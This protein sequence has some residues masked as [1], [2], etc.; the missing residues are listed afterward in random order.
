MYCTKLTHTDDQGKVAMVDT[1]EKPETTRIAVATA[2]VQLNSEI[3]LLIRENLIKK[4][5]AKLKEETCEVHITSRV[6]CDGKTGVEMEALVAASTAALTVYDMCKA[7]SKGI[8]IKEVKLLSKS[9]GK[10]GDY[11]APEEIHVRD[12]NRKPTRNQWLPFVG[13]V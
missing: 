2:T 7:V 6:R 5:K 13:P 10:S 12:F 11:H 9:G 1:G 4:V 8:V 3:T